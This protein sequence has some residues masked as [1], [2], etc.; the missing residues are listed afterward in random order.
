MKTMTSLGI[1]CVGLLLGLLLWG[2]AHAGTVTYVYSD[3][4]GTPLAEADASGA[5]TATFDYRPYGGQALGAA[6]SGPGYTGH[7]NDPESGLVYMQARYYDPSVGRFLSTDPV[8]PSPG[9]LS[10]FNRYDYANN[11]P[12][13]NIDPDGRNGQLYWTASNKVTLIIPYIVGESGGAH[14]SMT[15]AQINEAVSRNLSGTVDVN[16]TPVTVVAKAVEANGSNTTGHTNFLNV[17]PD[18]NGVTKSGR[19]E[20]NSVG[21]DRVT[22]GAT[23]SQ[24]A[25]PTTV[26]HEFGHVAGAGDQYKGGVDVNGNRLP[27]DAPGSSGIMNSLSDGPANQQTLNEIIRAPTNTNTC[28]FGVKAAGGGC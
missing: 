5:I 9:N 19:A 11:N 3:P 6:P 1:K 13:L 7:V 22:I 4:Q 18:T 8:G 27:Q 14:M 16:G 23:G 15:T 25:T 17:V 24:R 28:S 26:S 20:T 21:G 12:I 2:A 10:H